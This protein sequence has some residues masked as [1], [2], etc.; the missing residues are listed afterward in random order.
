MVEAGRGAPEAA[1]GRAVTATLALLDEA[2]LR[3]SVGKCVMFDG[4]AAGRRTKRGQRW[5]P[6]GVK[7]K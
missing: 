6:R 2:C 7:K 3:G 1:F 5:G 4:T